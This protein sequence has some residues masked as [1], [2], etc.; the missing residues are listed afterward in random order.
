MFKIYFNYFFLSALFFCVFVFVYVCVCVC[1]QNDS[2]GGK[3][4]LYLFI[5]IDLVGVWQFAFFSKRHCLLNQYLQ[6]IFPILKFYIYVTFEY[7]FTL[8]VLL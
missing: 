5:G 2:L 4:V 6:Y 7:M 1:V 8:L 3:Q